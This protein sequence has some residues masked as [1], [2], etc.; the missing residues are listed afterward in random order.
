LGIDCP[1]AAI[2]GVFSFKE[3]EIGVQISR[4]PGL[5]LTD[6]KKFGNGFGETSFRLDG[7]QWWQAICQIIH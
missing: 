3:S 7:F 5:P 4:P 1:K 6:D 2:Q